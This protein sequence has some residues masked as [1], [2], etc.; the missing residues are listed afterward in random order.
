MKVVYL[1]YT[2]NTLYEHKTRMKIAN[3]RTNAVFVAQKIC[4]NLVISVRANVLSDFL[5]FFL[6]IALIYM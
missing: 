5:S 3:G 6:V 2:V 4:S 1:D